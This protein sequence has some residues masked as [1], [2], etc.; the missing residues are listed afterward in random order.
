MLYRSY[1]PAR[2]LRAFVD[3]IWLCV[4]APT[5][6]KI[7]VLPSGT[8]EL[9]I[10]LSDDVIRMYD[11]S[12]ADRCLRYSGAV[13]SGPFRGFFALDPMEHATIMGVHFRPGGAVPFLGVPASELADTHVDL[14]AIWGRTA[15]ELR[16]CLCA[17]VTPAE[18]FAL[19]E[20][21]LLARLR[22]TRER[23]GAT[24][25]AL[26][27]FDQ[28]HGA[29]KVRDVAQQV[30]LSHR[31]FIQ[32]FAED[33]GLTPKMYGRVCRFQ[34]ARELV[35]NISA[36]DWAEVAAACGYFDQSH[37]IRDF[38]QFAGLS[39]AAYVSPRSEPI[40]PNRVPQL[41]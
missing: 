33:V 38:G 5:Y 17:A 39:P 32:V 28:A 13:V 15:A 21:A 11:A 30:G 16:E 23:H 20:E 19:L 37:L 36:P 29:V 22:E 35:R 6:P 7:R 31:R 24:T 1:T 3:R 14:D 8:M 18:R 4:D 10:N 34:R 27:T 12:D 25:V 40:L 9:A 41:G 26:E 2:P